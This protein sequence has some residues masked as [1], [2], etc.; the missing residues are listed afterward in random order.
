[1]GID[2]GLAYAQAH[3]ARV[4]ELVLRG[5]FLL[6]RSEIDWYYN[7]GASHLFPDRWEEYLAP[8]PDEERDGDLVACLPPHPDRPGFGPRT[9]GRVGLDAVG[10]VDE[11]SDPRQRDD[12][13]TLGSRWHSPPSRTTTSPTADSCATGSCSTTSM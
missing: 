1:M 9:T 2:L 3:P 6:R 13:G 4:T 7:G 11:L 5:I 10:I 12:A 8:I